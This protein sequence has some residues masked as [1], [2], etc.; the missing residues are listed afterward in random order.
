MKVLAA[1]INA[2]IGD[3]SGNTHKILLAIEVAKKA[4]CD[5]LITP[6]LAVTGYPPEDFLLL[7]QFIQ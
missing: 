5:L 3:I 6:E 2:T 7:H 4:G 1:Q